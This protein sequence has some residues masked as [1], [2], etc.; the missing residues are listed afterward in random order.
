MR[1]FTIVFIIT[2]VICLLGYYFIP[3][4]KQSVKQFPIKSKIDTPENKTLPDQDL[5]GVAFGDIEYHEESDLP[6]RRKSI[7]EFDKPKEGNKL[8]VFGELESPDDPNRY[9]VGVTYKIRLDP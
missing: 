3:Q 7:E 8:G 9:S 1:N 2:F 4:N 5:K 6:S